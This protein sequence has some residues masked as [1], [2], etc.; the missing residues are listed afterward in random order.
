METK[1]EECE[2]EC[3]HYSSMHGYCENCGE[4]TE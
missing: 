2:K 3:P 4:S 1:C